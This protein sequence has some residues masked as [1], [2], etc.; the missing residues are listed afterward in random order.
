ML[1]FLLPCAPHVNESID[2]FCRRR[3]RQ[4]RNV[5]SHCGLWSL[6]WAK[7]VVDWQSHVLRGSEYDHFCSSLVELHDDHWVMSQRSNYI[8]NHN[9]LFAGN[10]GTRLNIGRPQVRWAHGVANANAALNARPCQSRGSNSLSLSTR[11]R[12]A[13]SF[14]RNS[15]LPRNHI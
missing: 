10:T 1:A 5:A 13:I 8:N 2:H 11:L 15:I 3:L 9:S 14:V 7:R 12:E 4:A 6:I